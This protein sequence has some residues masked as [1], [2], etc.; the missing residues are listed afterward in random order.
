MS[1]SSRS[2]G[3]RDVAYQVHPFTNLR[4]HEVEGP[5]V[6]TSGK[7]IYVYDDAGREYIEAMAGLWCTSLGFGEE[8][9]V[10][11]AA[12]QMRKL[13][14]YHLFAHKTNDVAVELAERLIDLVPVP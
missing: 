7:G 14:Y 12:R 13:P 6:V 4:R 10:E 8:R 3:Q 2:I 11:A 9:L 1:T 5:Q